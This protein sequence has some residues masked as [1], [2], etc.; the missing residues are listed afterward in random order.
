MRG[1]ILRTP[2]SRCVKHTKKH[3]KT[4]KTH[5]L[6]M[7]CAPTSLVQNDE[8]R[9]SIPTHETLL[10]L[11]YIME[12]LQFVFKFVYRILLHRLHVDSH[13]P[14]RTACWGGGK[15][16]FRYI[17]THLDHNLYMKETYGPVFNLIKM[18][19]GQFQ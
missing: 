9:C 12:I 11:I 1:A 18:K 8:P 2:C 15:C 4:L 3:K 14:H 19:V 6:S 17:D 13:R 16:H 7:Q 10:F 5:W